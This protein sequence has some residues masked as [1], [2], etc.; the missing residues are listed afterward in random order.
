MNAA[1]EPSKLSIVL[2]V[3]PGIGER[4][5]YL[6]G[7]AIA[8]WTFLVT[9]SWLQPWALSGFFSFLM[10]AMVLLPVWIVFVVLTVQVAMIL[11][12][13]LTRVP[14]IPKR[15]VRSVPSVIVLALFSG[16]AL[17]SFWVDTLLGQLM[18]ASWFLGMALG[19]SWRFFCGKSE[20]LIA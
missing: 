4:E 6:V 15:W 10:A 17:D 18:G 14:G 19:L 9:V 5:A 11:A 16:V 3:V 2:P 8:A 1:R 12:A 13:I 20:E 7:G